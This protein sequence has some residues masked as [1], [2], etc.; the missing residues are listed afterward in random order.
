M[1][2]IEPTSVYCNIKLKKAVL[3]AGLESLIIRPVLQYLPT[4]PPLLHKRKYIGQVHLTNVFFKK[5]EF[6]NS[7]CVSDIKSTND[8]VTTK[9]YC[10]PK[11][12]NKRMLSLAFS[13]F[14]PSS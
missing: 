8:L 12:Y 2:T 14:N 7:C 3:M 13:V 5:A 11:A 6:K 1:G 9:Q 4:R 10:T